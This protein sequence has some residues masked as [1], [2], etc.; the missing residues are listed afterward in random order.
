MAA[1]FASALDHIMETIAKK[2]ITLLE[3]FRSYKAVRVM[4][5][6][7]RSAAIFYHLFCSAKTIIS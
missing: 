7:L 6:I 5:M 4:K 2:V 3:K 1:T